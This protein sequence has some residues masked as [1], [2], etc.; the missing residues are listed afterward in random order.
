MST[1][2]MQNIVIELSC[3]KIV[4]W[5]ASRTCVQLVKEEQSDKAALGNPVPGQRE[6]W[7]TFSA[8][9]DLSF[10]CQVSTPHDEEFFPEK[11][12]ACLLC[13]FTSMQVVR[14]PNNSSIYSWQWW[15]W[16]REREREGK[17][18][19]Q[20]GSSLCVCVCICIVWHLW[21][22][23]SHWVHKQKKGFPQLELH[24]CFSANQSLLLRVL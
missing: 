23:N 24:C 16:E 9:A 14:R 10:V 5:R 1:R 17:V 11:L 19:C 8:S 22:N 2:N 18:V 3:Q 6:P 13:D 21:K 4:S 20:S 15:V 12:G 7:V